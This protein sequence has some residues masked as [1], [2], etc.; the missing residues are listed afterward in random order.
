M[1]QND[2]LIEEMGLPV[3]TNKERVKLRSKWQAQT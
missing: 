1:S 3:L 2:R